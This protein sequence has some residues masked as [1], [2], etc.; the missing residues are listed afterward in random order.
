VTGPRRPVA[1]TALNVPAHLHVDDGHGWC[2]R[3]QES[4]TY[5]AQL[6]TDRRGRTLRSVL[7]PDEPPEPE[8]AVPVHDVDAA[9]EDAWRNAILADGPPEDPP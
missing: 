3:C 5:L 7:P 9:V 4:L 6:E 1:G 2:R 8:P